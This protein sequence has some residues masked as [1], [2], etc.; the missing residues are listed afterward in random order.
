MGES[1]NAHPYQPEIIEYCSDAIS[2][3]CSFKSYNECF[4]KF[5]VDGISDTA[6]S[7]YRMKVFNGTN[8]IQPNEPLQGSL[9]H[10]GDVDYYWFVS[11][12]A[13]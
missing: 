13:V 11:T 5:R 4:L 3:W 7:F 6:T 12:V 10:A 9:T 2:S 1:S 8:K